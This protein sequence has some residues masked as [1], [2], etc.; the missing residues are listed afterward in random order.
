MKS[1]FLTLLFVFLAILCS[2]KP[3]PVAVDGRPVAEILLKPDADITLRH[4]A[5]EL[6]KWLRE[7]TGAELPIVAKPGDAPRRIRLSAADD[8]LKRFPADAARLKGTDG[9]AVRPDGDDLCLFGATSKGVL[10]GVYRLLRRNTDI[11]WARPDEAL[12]TIFTA[13]PTLTLWDDDHIDVPAFGLRGWKTPFPLTGVD[14]TWNV[15]QCAN[16]GTQ[17]MDKAVWE[18]KK[19]WG[20]QQEFPFG[21]N[22]TVMYMQRGRYWKEHPEW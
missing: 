8:V 11:I 16:W 12:G 19:E 17:P 4:A 5:E 6:Q 13:T 15:R 14:L 3:F 10:N 2:A 7:I 20:V 21:H 18:A 1:H 22:I 9:Y